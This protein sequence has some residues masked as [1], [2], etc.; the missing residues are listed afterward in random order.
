[1]T[2]F[3]GDVQDETLESEETIY[4]DKSDK[5]LFRPSVNEDVEQLDVQESNSISYSP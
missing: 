3:N 4:F 1:M 2:N 5:L